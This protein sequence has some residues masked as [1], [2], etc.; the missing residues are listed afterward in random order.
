MGQ[1]GDGMLEHVLT[2]GQNL[3]DY[4]TADFSFGDFNRGFN[5]GE[6]EPFNAKSVMADIAPFCRQEA[7]V[8]IVFG[9]AIRQKFC[10]ARLGY[11]VKFLVLPKRIIRVQTDYLQLF[12]H[13]VMHDLRQLPC[14]PFSESP[15]GLYKGTWTMAP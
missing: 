13:W 6:H 14:G 11:A 4:C 5:H 3:P 8:Q 1:Q 9:A 15:C 10:K 12:C 7:V 2:C